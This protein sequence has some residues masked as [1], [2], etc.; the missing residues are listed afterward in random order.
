MAKK[1]RNQTRAAA[2]A[3]TARVEVMR[4]QVLAMSNTGM[5]C[6]QIGEAL[7]ISRNRAWQLLNEALE[8]LHSE[9]MDKTE[10]WRAIMS[11]KW[12]VQMAKGE[13]L[14]DQALARGDEPPVEGA[15]EPTLPLDTLETANGMLERSMDKLAKIWGVYAPV[16][17]ESKAEVQADVTSKGEAIAAPGLSSLSN[18]ALEAIRQA[19]LLAQGKQ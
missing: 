1:T 11:Q 5:T 4:D 15:K 12:L 2:G 10:H 6:P 9:T 17:T 18:E 14:R 19:H 13:A 7:G 8:M 16:K 3:T